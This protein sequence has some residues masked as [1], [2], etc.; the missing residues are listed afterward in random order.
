MTEL[1]LDYWRAS[2]GYCET[3]ENEIAAP[4]LFDMADFGSSKP[5]PS[6][7]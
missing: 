7:A 5:V 1:N 4:T 2:V 3:A 6:A